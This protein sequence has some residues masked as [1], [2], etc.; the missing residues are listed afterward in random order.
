VFTEISVIQEFEYPVACNH[1][2]MTPDREHIISCGT[3]KPRIKIHDLSEH[4]MK[5]ERHME[6][7]P[8]KIEVLGRDLSKLAVLRNDR[9]IEFHAKYGLHDTIR[10]P[11]FGED[12]SFLPSLSELLVVGRS[13]SVI[14]FNLERGR[15]L[16]PIESEFYEINSV[17]VSDVHGLVVVGGAGG[18]GFIDPRVR[19]LIKSMRTGEDITS[20]CYS[21]NGLNLCV[22]DALGGIKAYDLRSKDEVLS[23]SHGNTAVKNVFFSHK[24]IISASGM[25]VR[26]WEGVETLLDLKMNSKINAMALDE[27]IIM[28]G[29]DEPVIRTYYSPRLGDVP[30]WCKPI[31]NLIEDGIA[32]S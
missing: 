18:F 10:L 13:N 14:R 23:M 5:L 31:E 25:Y 16:K 24:N 12:I 7:E 3:Y 2:K 28:L 1:L 17:K 26:L 29:T 21:D 15:F 20:L 22:G 6:A 8:L 11:K 30:G 27:G 9:V 4:S 19:K 32:T